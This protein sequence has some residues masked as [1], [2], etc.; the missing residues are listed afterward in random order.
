MKILG[1]AVAL[2]SVALVA[3]TNIVVTKWDSG[4]AGDKAQTRCEQADMRDQEQMDRIFSAYDGWNLVYVSEVA[5][6]D[7][8]DAVICFDRVSDGTPVPQIKSKRTF[9]NA[10]HHGSDA[11]F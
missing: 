4:V 6:G 2:S 7:G 3:C 1:I 8:T 5:T 10:H 11:T 9:K